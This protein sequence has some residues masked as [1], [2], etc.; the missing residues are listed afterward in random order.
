VGP[1]AV[2]DTVVK[3]KIPGPCRESSP[4][5]L[6]VQPIAQQHIHGVVLKHRDIFTFTFKS[7]T[8]RNACETSFGNIILK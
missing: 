3:R 7:C 8:R 1:R 2:L 6:I 4:R 5:I